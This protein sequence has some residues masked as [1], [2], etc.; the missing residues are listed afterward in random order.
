MLISSQQNNES[1]NRFLLLKVYVS[2]QLKTKNNFAQID[3]WLS[4]SRFSKNFETRFLKLENAYLWTLKFP[5]V[6]RNMRK[7]EDRSK[8]G[9]QKYFYWKVYV[10]SFQMPCR[11]LFLDQNSWRTI[12]LKYWSENL[13]TKLQNL[14][15]IQQKIIKSADFHRIMIFLQ[16]L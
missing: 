4:K 15:K 3:I 2:V 1:T 10:F 5:Q 14:C 7:N 9:I 13:I 16:N 11:S 8:V 12:V 6:Y